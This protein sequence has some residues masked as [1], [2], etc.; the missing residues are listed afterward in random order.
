MRLE[1]SRHVQGGTKLVSEIPQKWWRIGMSGL[2]AQKALIFRITH[3]NNVPWI[4]DHGL[5][6]HNSHIQDPNFV[7]IGMKELIKRRQSRK[8]EI[9]PGGTLSDYIPFYFTPYSIMMYNIK[10]G[11]N[12]VIKRPN[13][14]IIILVS[15]IPLL[16]NK[17]IQFVFTDAH[18]YTFEA[19][20]F[21]SVTDLDKIDW[22]LLNKR[23]FSGDPD[24]SAKLGRYQA[25]TLVYQHLPVEGLLGIACYNAQVCQ[26]ISTLV[27]THGQAI[28]VKVCSGWYF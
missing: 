23:D 12:D 26:N 17:G 8:V 14:E 27:Q 10:T 28:S 11:Y 9:E 16:I 25:E 13:D 18:A 7:S 24:D 21:N 2:N 1:R 3:R 5:H 6:C 20:Y 4:L 15:S 22:E 19:N